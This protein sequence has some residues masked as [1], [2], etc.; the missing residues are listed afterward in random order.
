MMIYHTSTNRQQS[1]YSHLLRELKRN[2]IHQLE[3]H[4]LQKHHPPLTKEG[5]KQILNR[6][7]TI[8]QVQKH[9]KFAQSALQ[10]EDFMKR[11]TTNTRIGVVENIKKTRRRRRKLNVDTTQV[12]E[13]WR[14]CNCLANVKRNQHMM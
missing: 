5:I 3:N 12:L 4:L 9:A 7:D 10:F 13:K 11:K 6:D 2:R 1:K 14:V 8:T